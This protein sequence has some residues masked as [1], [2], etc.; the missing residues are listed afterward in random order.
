MTYRPTRGYG[1]APPKA[2]FVCAKAP[3][4]S[5]T[6]YQKAPFNTYAKWVHDTCP[7]VYAFAYAYYPANANES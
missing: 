7:G 3:H 2:P 1:G 4:R 5:S 6:P